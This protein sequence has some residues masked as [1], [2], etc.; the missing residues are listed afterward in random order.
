[1]VGESKNRA[2]LP[3]P[4]SLIR[5]EVKIQGYKHVAVARHGNY[6]G[7]FALL[8]TARRLLCVNNRPLDSSE[9]PTVGALLAYGWGTSC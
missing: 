1:M 5:Q 8:R 7:P 6:A 9:W 2:P 4:L 3:F